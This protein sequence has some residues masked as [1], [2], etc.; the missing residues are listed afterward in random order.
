MV[1]SRKLRKRM[2]KRYND[3]TGG[4][5]RVLMLSYVTGRCSIRRRMDDIKRPKLIKGR[6][7]RRYIQRLN[8]N[9][10]HVNATTRYSVISL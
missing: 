7:V 4:R 9:H 3:R 2:T 8:A 6:T 10:K 5:D 1:A